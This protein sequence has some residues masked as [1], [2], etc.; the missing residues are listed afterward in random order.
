MERI[1]TN[2]ASIQNLSK[3]L[4]YTQS[5]TIPFAKKLNIRSKVF[6]LGFIFIGL[7]GMNGWG[8]T[9]TPA[10]NAA[11][12]TNV[13][14]VG[15]I[16]W[17]TP[18]NIVGD[19]NSYAT[20]SLNNNISNFLQATGYGFSIP[21]E[22]TIN[23]ITVI[24]GRFQNSTSGTSIT[25]NVVRLIKG[26]TISG[27]NLAT[28]TEW[29]TSET[30]A[31]YGGIGNLWGTSW[32]PANINAANFGVALAADCGN[33]SRTGSV[34]YITISVTFTGTYLSQWVAMNTGSSTWCA[35][36]TRTVTVT[37]KN[38]GNRTWTDGWP[39]IN[40]GVKWNGDA[41]YHVRTDAG[42]LAPGAT[43]T[44]SFSVTA[45]A[46]GNNN[47]T[48]DAVYEQLTW[49][50]NNGGGV[51]P[52]NVVYASPA[53]TITNVVPSQPS[54]IAGNATPCEGSSQNYSVT[55][56]SGVTYNW[57]L[58]AGWSQTGGGTSNSVTV[59]VGSGTGNIQ[60]TPSNACGNGTARTLTVTPTSVPAQP[61]AITG[62]TTPCQGSSQTYSV[63]NIADVIYTWVLPSGWTGTS[64]TNSITVTVGATSG[65]VQVTPS[66]T[67]GS[68]TVRALPVTVSPLPEAAGAITGTSA[69]C[70][71]RTNLDYSVASISNATSYLWEYSGTGATI[72]GT[73]NSITI[74]FASNA[75]PGS[76][77][78]K[79]VNTC[80]TGTSSSQYAISF[81]SPNTTG[82]AICQGGS[83]S[84]T[85]STTCPPGNPTPIGPSFPVT[86]STSGSGTAWINPT[87]V[88]SNDNSYATVSITSGFG[89]AS[90]TSQSLSA[91]Q[92][93][94]NIPTDAT[95]LGIQ[96]SIGRFANGTSIQDNSVRLIKAGSVIGSNYGLTTTNWGTSETAQAYGSTNDLWGTSWV[97]S[98]INAS[99]FGISL[100]VDISFNNWF[101]T[102]TASVDY[103]QI[104]VTYTVNGVL[105]WYTASSGGSPIG[106]GSTFNPVG[107]SGSGL[108]STNTPGTTTF[109]AECSTNPGC[110]TATD[111]KIAPG[112]LT[113]D[114]SESNAWENANNWEQTFIPISCTDVTIPSGL[115]N[116]PTISSSASCNNITIESGASLLGN[117]FLTVS[118]KSEL[119]REIETNNAWHFLSS[120]I[121]NHPIWP[122]FAPT[123]T[124]TTTLTFGVAPWKWDFYYF[125]PNADFSTG[126]FW[127]NLRMATTGNLN[128]AAVDQS[129][130]NAGFGSN[131]PT[132]TSGRGYLVAYNEEWNPATGSPKIHSFNGTNPSTFFSGDLTISRTNSSQAF[133]L[134][135]NPYPSSI[136]WKENAGWD[137][138]D[139]KPSS[140]G[141]DYW[142]MTGTGNYGVYNSA[143]GDDNGTSNVTR[144]IAPAQ[145]FMVEATDL[146]SFSMKILEAARVHSSQPWLKNEVFDPGRLRLKITTSANTY[147]DEMIVA[148]N[149]TYTGNGGSAKLFSWYVEAP[150]IYSVKEGNNFSIDRYNDI[151]TD[152]TVNIN[153][154]TGIEADYTIT[155]TNISDFNLSSKV[156]LEDLKTGIVTDLKQT[157]AYTFAGS[158][159]DDASRFRLIIGSPIGIDEPNTNGSFNI[160]TYENMVYVQN[161]KINESYFVTVSNMLGQ[162]LVRNNF[163]GNSLNRIEMHSVPGVYVVNVVSNGKTY[164]QKVVIR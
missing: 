59:N 8:Q 160:Y 11:T 36:E 31:S 54:V 93:N 43:Q 144:Y 138:N 22:A 162:V 105:N 130:D 5:N 96:A 97:P 111:F 84:L 120:P 45:P 13:T 44:Y 17:T 90:G 153:T 99:N 86:A 108:P 68:G 113:W 143:D 25:D 70:T 164:S 140:G 155:A 38:N 102:M 6:W 78:V 1:Y 100:I 92:F 131:N 134:V 15:T 52:G 3:E 14:G 60:V 157:P 62:S 87:R 128:I 35:G 150:E 141:F 64:T 152:I 127:V 18:G 158:P 104:T 94:F 23:G 72:N 42:N 55:N 123:P 119:K 88:T 83:G 112:S 89:S 76:L 71:L 156:L 109:Y 69:V 118:S 46:A 29:P 91:T 107:V 122:E 65:N 33:V 110:R 125:N 73:T 57:T 61:A 67:C 124:G 135:G 121:V 74:D 20:I 132:F 50:A 30:A 147:S 163:S 79:G 133:N 58:P 77:T 103:M 41:D 51:G 159:G 9:T 2:T 116:Y 129:G 151:Q 145:G 142:I 101:T 136:D 26:G 4:P 53:I 49:F 63:T 139:L 48:F 7:I 28:A 75:T 39:D 161:D 114:G 85:S 95:V 12:G 98:E 117:S 115:T 80:G 66:N 10:R 82:V 81:N 34:D 24:V 21:S 149:S 137:R 126:L 148:Y 27:N 56:V 32:S 40:I 37:L 154:K 47:L 19:E 106:S 16:A 146:G